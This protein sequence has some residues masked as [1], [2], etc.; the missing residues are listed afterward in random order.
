MTV[1][2]QYNTPSLQFKEALEK[3]ILNREPLF[4]IN[5]VDFYV[6]AKGLTMISAER[7]IQY[8][9]HLRF[10][11]QIGL[12]KEISTDYI[13]DAIEELEEL[14]R[15]ADDMREVTKKADSVI[16]MLR[17]YEAHKANTSIVGMMLELCSIALITPCENPYR[18]DY[19]YN[20][21]KIKM[22]T[23]AMEQPNGEEFTLFFWK[24]TS[25]DSMDWIGRLMEFTPYWAKDEN[26]MTKE[27]K[28]NYQIAQNLLIL[29]ILKVKKKV[30]DI[31]LGKGSSNRVK[32]L[33]NTLNLAKLNLNS[34]VLRLISNTKNSPTGK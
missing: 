13:N 3:G 11:S 28:E 15:N 30:E 23:L 12:S 20:A 27:E 33:R 5:G 16:T 29:D 9:E 1:F 14:R 22:M 8:Q 26:Q 17:L 19:E 24:L 2:E 31:R 7:Y 21:E 18:I 10:Y 6:F 4:S 25:L 34:R 32:G